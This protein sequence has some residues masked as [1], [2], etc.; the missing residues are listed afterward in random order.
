MLADLGRFII[1]SKS[2]EICL[3]GCVYILYFLLTLHFLVILGGGERVLAL[4]VC[5]FVSLKYQSCEALYQWRC[6]RH[7]YMNECTIYRHWKKSPAELLPLRISQIK[8]KYISNLLT[9]ISKYSQ[10]F[11]NAVLG[12]TEKDN[13]IHCIIN[14]ILKPF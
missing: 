13:F 8:N 3:Q 12:G 6:Y 7:E 10:T 4:F 2:T 5:L 9:E 11:W 1:I 14:E